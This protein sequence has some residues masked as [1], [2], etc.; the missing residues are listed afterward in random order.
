MKAELTKM[1]RNFL[2]GDDTKPTVGID[3]LQLPYE[4]GGKKL[5]NLSIRNDA[6]ELM[7][8]KRYLNFG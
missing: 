8:V 2:W 1:I 6:I 5:L 7:K 3:T 4:R